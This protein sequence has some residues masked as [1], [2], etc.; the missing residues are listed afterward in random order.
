M[1]ERFFYFVGK[2]LGSLRESPGISVLTAGT[3]GATLIVLGLFVML[4]QNV[5]GLALVWGRNATVAVYLDDGLTPEQWEGLREDLSTLDAVERSVLLTPEEALERFRDSGSDAAALVEGVRADILP[6]SVE[7]FLRAAFADAESLKQLA[8]RIAELPGVAEVDY[9]Q[10]E[11]A[12]LM[13]LLRF[14]RLSGVA[15]GLLLALATSFIVSNTIRLTVYARR[16]EIAIQQ[17]VGATSWF[18]RAP[19]LLE[20]A[21]WGFGGGVFAALALWFAEV[22]VADDVS[23]WVA[24]IVGGLRIQLFSWPLA[25]VMVFVGV[26]LGA[27][28]SALAVGRFLEVHEL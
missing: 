6:A 23:L 15:V 2:A 22:S 14:L 5:E 16:D 8:I 13:T 21:L 11:L 12:R 27:V 10:D 1:T 17:L 28:G 4:L 3:I 20:G 7:L 25:G 26:I 18:V 19:F 24:N 9:G